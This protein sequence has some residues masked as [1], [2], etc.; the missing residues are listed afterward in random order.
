MALHE[1]VDSLRTKHAHLE[2]MIDEELHRPL[3]DQAA[4]SRLKKEK[5]RIKEEIERL[6]PAGFGA[7]HQVSGTA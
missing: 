5:L 6:R 7:A 4:L 2:Q 3:P 1:H